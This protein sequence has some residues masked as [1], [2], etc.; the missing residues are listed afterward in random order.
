[1]KEYKAIVHAWTVMG[2]VDCCL[3]HFSVLEATES[4]LALPLLP[5]SL[6]SLQE[7]AWYSQKAGQGPGNVAK[8]TVNLVWLC[9][10][11]Q[12]CRPFSCHGYS[13]C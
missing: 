12:Y 3:Q 1:M 7:E 10:L 5:P 2:K 4:L 8:Y 13:E 6:P 9:F 11:S